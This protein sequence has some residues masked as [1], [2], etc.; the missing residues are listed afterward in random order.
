VLNNWF[1]IS[2]SDVPNI[3]YPG[4]LKHS[5]SGTVSSATSGTFGAR[6]YQCTISILFGLV[7]S[8]LM[9]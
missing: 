2:E 6:Y 3:R 1:Y 4:V 7:L 5:T 9:G 8:L